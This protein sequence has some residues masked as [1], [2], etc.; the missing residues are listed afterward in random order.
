[1]L[2]IE[3]SQ[4]K[5]QI[6]LLLT[7][8]GD[9][10]WSLMRDF[11][12]RRLI[13]N[14]EQISETIFAKT[15]TIRGQGVRVI[16]RHNC[17]SQ[18]FDVSFDVKFANL[19]SEI[20]AQVSNILDLHAIPDVIFNALERAG[21]RKDQLNL[22]L[23]IPGI[24]SR[25]EA[26]VRAIL[27]QQV[28]VKAA[29]TQVNRLQQGIAGDDDKLITPQQ[30]A[31]SDLSFLKLPA[32]RKG[33]LTLFAQLMASQEDAD[34]EQW[35]AIKGIGPWTVN[36]VRLRAT[37]STDIWL[38]TDLVIRQK[39]IALTQAGQTLNDSQAAPWRSYLTLSLWNLL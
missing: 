15:L 28:S 4:D 6:S 30:L 9:Y 25:F 32:S 35:L 37:S 20:I 12:A 27:G 22:G 17:T 23:R 10:D 39:M 29:I 26:G 18:G 36:Y 33:A 14:N 19:S 24:N 21:L 13:Q 31:Q 38:N 7:Y 5:N 8:Q 2:T 3:Q 16:M 11:F 34:F 1:M